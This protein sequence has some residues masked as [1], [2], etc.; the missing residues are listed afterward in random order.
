M[1][2]PIPVFDVDLARADGATD[3]QI[4]EFLASKAGFN[5]DLARKDGASDTAIVDFLTA[6]P[7]PA[8]PEKPAS[9]LMG[10]IAKTV[11]QNVLKLPGG[12]VEAA[13]ST[14]E[15]GALVDEANSRKQL[16]IYDRVDRG[17][18]IKPLAV[19]GMGYRQDQDLIWANQYA[20]ASPEEKDVLRSRAAGNLKA[21]P[22]MLE[23][24][25][26]KLRHSGEK[27]IGW[28]E[29]TI[30]LNEEE[31]G[32][33]SVQVT[34]LLTRMVPYVA[35][36]VATGGSG[37][38]GY[39][40][41][42]SLN[43]TYTE[44]LKEGA[45]PEKAAVGAVENGFMQGFLNVV[46]A[47]HAA[48]VMKR[49]PDAAKGKFVQLLADAALGA[50]NMLG[51]T[52]VSKLAENAVAEKTFD[53][54]RPW[55]KG[56]GEN[57]GP[58][59][60]A[61][62]ILPLGA[63]A[64]GA[65]ARRLRG[66]QPLEVA[67]E[68]TDQPTIDDAITKAREVVEGDPVDTEAQAIGAREFGGTAD[69]Q[70]AKML[71]LFGGLNEGAV[72]VL[73]GGQYQYRIDDKAIPLKIWDERTPAVEG[74]KTISP[75]LATTQRRVY[76][77]MG[78]DVV[79]IA[80]DGSVPFD[81][82]VSPRNPDTI[83]LSNDPQRNAAQVGA[84][85]IT[86][87][88][89]SVTTP[90]GERLAD[91]MHQKI[92]KD[93]TGAGIDHYLK[94]FGQDAPARADFEEGATGDSR[95][96]DAVWRHITQELGAD[97]GGEAPKFQTF[98]PKVI[99][100]VQARYGDDAAKSVTR[101]LMDGIQTAMRRL[102]E[103]FSKGDPGAE[104]GVPDTVSQTWLTNLGEMHDILAKGWAEK[105]GT[106]AERENVALRDMR[107]R[108]A[109]DRAIQDERFGVSEI[110]PPTAPEGFTS[111]DVT[112]QVRPD[113][114]GDPNAPLAAEVKRL[115]Q[116]RA[117]TNAKANEA[118][119]RGDTAERDRLFDEADKIRAQETEAQSR[120]DAAD[121]ERRTGATQPQG[122][123]APAPGYQEAAQKVS[124]YQRW[125][126][127][128]DEE[129][130]QAAPESPQAR[131][132][133]QTEAAILGKV[134]GVEDRL[135]KIAATRLG[136]VRTQ[137]DALLNPVDDSPSMAKVREGLLVEQQRMAD[138]AAARLPEKAPAA[139][140]SNPDPLARV[141]PVPVPSPEQTAKPGIVAQETAPAIPPSAPVTSATE[142]RAPI[143]AAPEPATPA[144]AAEIREVEQSIEEIRNEKNVRNRPDFAETQAQD[145]AELEA[146][147]AGLK[148]EGGDLRLEPT[149]GR[150]D[151]QLGQ[152]E[153]A[154]AKFSPKLDWV[155]RAFT[156]VLPKG[157]AWVEKAFNA[158]ADVRAAKTST[159]AEFAR[160][161]ESA[162]RRYDLPE[163]DYNRFV[164]RVGRLSLDDAGRLQQAIEQRTAQGDAYVP[165]E[166]LVGAR[167]RGPVT[168]VEP[169]EQAQIGQ[170]ADATAKFSPK[171]GEVVYR[172]T[173]E[174][175][176][177]LRA[178]DFSGAWV[179]PDRA[180]AS[181][182]G[183]H[184]AAHRISPEAKFVDEASPEGWAL[185]EKW[186]KSEGYSDADIR[187]IRDDGFIPDN[188]PIA[189]PDKK[190]AALL[191][192]AGYDGH[193]EGDNIFVAEHA[194]GKVAPDTEA[195]LSPKVS[196]ENDA[197]G[198]TTRA[199][200]LTGITRN[201]REAGYVTTDGTML[202]MSG[203]HEAVGYERR[204][205]RFTPQAGQP[206]YLANARNTDHRDVAQALTDGHTE[207]G[208]AMQEFMDRSGA[209]RVDFNSGNITATVRPTAEQ[210][211]A[212]AAAAKTAG[213]D[214]LTVEFM[215]ADGH[216]ISHAEVENINPKNI[217]RV[218]NDRLSGE[219]LFSP[220]QLETPE[221]KR[222]FGDSK[223][224]DEE[225][226]PIVVYHGTNAD[227]NV[228]NTNAGKGK[229]HGGG[230]IFT[231]RP[232]AANTYATG[233]NPNVMPAYVS[234]QNPVVIDAGGK[235]WN[236]IG[237]SARINLPET[238][239]SA[240]SDNKLLADLGV[241][242][243][244]NSPT[245]KLA[246][247][248]TTLGRI[249]KGEMGL[250][251][252]ASTDDV[253]RW[254]RSQGY[255]SVIIKNVVDRG[256]SGRFMTP[257]AS[258][259]QTLYVAFD[260][261]QIKSA[262][263]NTGA[264]DPTNPDIR[265]SPKGSASPERVREL[266]R[267]VGGLKGLLK[268]MEPDELAKL[269]KQ[270]ASKIV[271]VFTNLPSAEEMAAVAYAGRAKKGWY[272]KSAKALLEIFGVEDAPRF[273]ALL[274][275][276]SPQV[277]VETN[278]INALNIWKNWDAAGRPTDKHS[279]IGIM[280]ESVQ[281]DKGIDSVLGAWVNNTVSA[282]SHPDPEHLDISGPKVNSFARNLRGHVND[283][284]LDAW[285]ANYANIEQELFRKTGPAP[286]KGYGYIAMSA[287]V[288][289]AAD[290]ISRRT[291][292]TWTPA[293]IQETVWSWA[294][295]LYEAV[296][297]KEETRT[298]KQLLE[299][300]GL[301]HESIAATPDFELL[302]VSG[303]YR[304]LLQEAGY[305][306]EIQT[307]ERSVA[308]REQPGGA[309]RL[310]GTVLPSEGS[311][312]AETA[313]SGHLKRAANRLDQLRER[314]AA[315][316]EPRFSPK[317]EEP[318]YSALTRGVEGLKL[319]KATPGQWEATVRNM[320]GVKAEERAWVGLDD[321]LKLQPKSVTKA[322]V[323]DYLRAN[324]IKVQ[325]VEKG[326]ALITPSPETVERRAIQSAV[327][328]GDIE[329]SSF[330]PAARPE[331]RDF[332]L[333]AARDDIRAEKGDVSAT[334]FA[335]Y[336]L[337]GGSNYRELLLTLPEKKAG[338]VP[339]KVEDMTQPQLA[340]LFM[341]NDRHAEEHAVRNATREALLDLLVRGED[342]ITDDTLRDYQQRGMRMD[343]NINFRGGHWEEANVLAHIRFDDR[344]GPN[345]ERVLHI[346][347]VQS[348]WHQ[349]GRKEGYQIERKPLTKDSL[350][351]ALRDDGQ[352]V[353][354]DLLD[355]IYDEATKGREV[356]V[357]SL[358]QNLGL[359]LAAA[360]RIAGGFFDGGIPSGVPDA[361][362][363]TTWPELAMK[364]MLRFAAENG[365][366][367]VSWDT[368]ETNAD[369]FDLSQR[370]RELRIF[371]RADGDGYNVNGKTVEGD[372]ILHHAK[373]G[374][375]LV[376]TVG[377]ELA[378]R[379]V[380]ELDEQGS[381]TSQGVKYSGLDL[382][383]GGEGMAAFYD[384]QL[385]VIANKLG[386]KF[387]AKVEQTTVPTDKPGEV[388]QDASSRR[389]F[390]EDENGAMNTERTFA[391]EAEARKAIEAGAGA[392]SIAITDAMRDGVMQG[393]PL[394]SPKTPTANQKRTYTPEQDAA[395]KAIGAEIDVPTATEWARGKTRGAGE[396]TI[397]ATLDRYYG[398]KSDDPTGY[399]GLRNSNTSGGAI[400]G[401]NTIG[402]LKFVGSA[403]ALKD[404]TGGVKALI[405]GLGDEAHD[406]ARWV[407]GNRAAILKT[408]GRENLLDDRAI[409][410]LK[411]LNQ[412][413][414][415]EPYTLA[416]G[417]TTT[418]RE[419][420]YLDS[421]RKYHELNKNVMDL[422]VDSGLI[423]RD[424]ADK[425][426]ANPYYIPFYRVDPTDGDQFVAP[427]SRSAAVGQTAFQKLKG[428]TEKLNH[429][430]W[431]N[432]DSNFAHL[433]EASL[434]NKNA[435][436]VLK[437]AVQ[438]GAAVKLTEQQ[439]KYLSDKEQK[440]NTVWVMENGEKSYYRI[441]NE[442]LMAAVSVL[443]PIS[444]HGLVKVGQVAKTVLQTGVTMSP[445]FAVKNIIRDTQQ[446]LATT[447]ISWN[448][449]KNL[450]TGFKENNAGRA[451]M[452]LANAATAEV[453]QAVKPTQM[454][455]A[456]ANAMIGG[457]LMR[458][459]DVSDTGIRR[460]SI[461]SM[462]INTPEAATNFWEKLKV[463]GNA[464][465]K[466]LA[467]GEDVS[468]IAL[469][470]QLIDQGV[471]HDF[472]A[473][474]ARDIA[475]FTLTGASQLVRT[476]NSMSAFTNARMQGLYKVA[477]AAGDAD[478]SIVGAVATRLAV[479][480]MARV[481]I[482]VLAGTLAG[483]ALDRIYADDEDFKKRDE[484]DRNS[485]YWFKIG[486]TQ[487]RIPKGFEVGA[488]SSLGTIF[489]ESFYD[490]EMT[491]GRAGKNLLH[492]LADNLNLNPTPTAIKPILDVAMNKSAANGAPIVGKG[493]E[494]LDPT[495]RYTNSN[496]LAS[497]G[498]SKATFGALSPVQIDYLTRAYTG[499]L[500]TTS[501]QI[502]DIV[503]RSV[504]SEPVRP[505]GDMMSTLTGGIVSSEARASSRYINMLY[506][507]GDGIEKAYNT[508]RD[509][510]NSGRRAEAV[511]YYKAHQADID[512]HGIVSSTMRTEAALNAQIRRIGNSTEMTAAEK[513]AQIMRINQLKSD[514]AQRAVGVR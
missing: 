165:K 117:A 412:G 187:E 423:K 487:F 447:P 334:K 363:K 83:F 138:A 328:S 106:A 500:G 263:G 388:Y 198:L 197:A 195:K 70:Q 407:A 372:P 110:P 84:H 200:E 304:K 194:L 414:L 344:T 38:V 506:E 16:D 514:A 453:F 379:A 85:E 127:Q 8:K 504:S 209:V 233:D 43:Q 226:K 398:I 459:G 235:N 438:Q 89:E 50:G 75:E 205:D 309:D 9:S 454:S 61:G 128:L 52:E 143:S 245:S 280:G 230:T 81:G 499:W 346:A 252:T 401:F 213:L 30:P 316:E 99:D 133:Q 450:Y 489:V 35:A 350:A 92:V 373:D 6:T 307:V 410:G 136:R 20:G 129:R 318:F 478:K 39:G 36:A 343:S 102:R 448:V 168:D 22:G 69:R 237:A 279:I 342:P 460:T 123:P 192:E 444:R 78:I 483:L 433:I 243:S 147:L 191:K 432:V 2:D 101:K 142:N 313:F 203:R 364:R 285:M 164:E 403:Y 427:N 486:S 353:D 452:N 475:D 352:P 371:K 154:E 219:A 244:A 62:A 193:R 418:S 231:D 497:R 476:I 223:A 303:V 148:G 255:E 315:D 281:G 510:L 140:G 317:S 60:I 381:D 125:L 349:K 5:L 269:K 374:A 217:A 492:I 439:Y 267:E 227:I 485:N 32:R 135:T 435:I 3:T 90:D 294:K 1:A 229:T 479:N 369:R 29:R 283:V 429:D 216:P 264:F 472:A 431:E 178:R 171:Q 120:L 141:E 114:A 425:L 300:G 42:E 441:E 228:F 201:P 324:E 362:F 470:S 28:A 286:G 325:E 319:D 189:F 49:L 509:K 4:A 79:Y 10:G 389:W 100:E 366:D 65:A 404:R 495:E 451:L 361:P 468:R 375:A 254:A 15:V 33:T 382:K 386:K 51:M 177:E 77:D 68:I 261:T 118:N 174:R 215:G 482:V 416:N 474:S 163:A 234:L 246:A 302:F 484:M 330:W 24:T 116:E 370:V 507:Q 391:T 420:A 358:E 161:L 158:Y 426:L 169:V 97:I 145:I 471:P 494:R 480:T 419:A 166:P 462:L 501:M 367:R 320:P 224:V 82:A 204:G 502:G 488:M 186:L 44:A 463:A 155:R 179:T 188:D 287:A 25:G 11:G 23:E 262:I 55:N 91:L 80:D 183:E 268:Y 259:P 282:L 151:I 212:I 109:R 351:K 322:E 293:E 180:N 236:A 455:D 121:A 199:K 207:G 222:W 277:S 443:D 257:E 27:M 266:T 348:D 297:A 273:A 152:A 251:E 512:K 413:T 411:S 253:I 359:S 19:G 465:R 434:R 146:K 305:G 13:G 122:L 345:G 45:D 185:R 242:T 331:I 274:A 276:T 326:S 7:E 289:K 249:F 54:A 336:V 17:E 436:P 498:I 406:F 214:R 467:Q 34:D 105:F 94:I 409:K 72:E 378:D 238:E 40:A 111:A 182:Y 232:E 57:M 48:S 67:K 160:V 424:V 206:D 37:L 88:L 440:A 104:Y 247:Q 387:G 284:T 74:I 159:T 14:A 332:H 365:Y 18:K 150:S 53:P 513:K 167:R 466:A 355:A 241:D 490:K 76:R 356:L 66:K 323:L 21:E 415:A 385:P 377:K 446:V 402:T 64:A 376:N 225:G 115:Q 240:R 202:D 170:G 357:D 107:D 210:I 93:V 477:R 312:F 457:G 196:D 119:D 408:E 445:H 221:F 473:F 108:A 442:G 383:V 58:A 132:L 437:T 417:T 329:A 139:K 162:L 310:V 291:G 392:H 173:P 298:A 335:S 396:K 126:G 96:A 508:Y 56:L 144:R 339:L 340:D 311:G 260:P 296:S 112:G 275:A 503:A 87:I 41:L 397:I 103:F 278:A 308:G 156:A 306:R 461:T 71:Q 456:A 239:V 184:V 421:L 95:H 130:R 131:L 86:H 400:E 384:K 399:F 380:K 149:G 301:T 337:P 491:A 314:R 124:T 393:Q 290:V 321:W 272:Q 258:L 299:A 292:E 59:A 505:A 175:E 176:T 47:A 250:G 208:F 341:F 31:K 265:Y 137:L 220:K 394:F 395:L 172:G 248:S 428:G 157:D 347:E 218:F 181:Q 368:G 405:D 360:N 449:A 469:Y 211:S 98:L 430:L 271:E 327:A 46:P 153:G 493:M 481:G 464:W 190:W 390:I 26:K 73:P 256:P 270:N 63:G 511:E 354:G 12:V 288:R 333:N 338:P 422:A 113:P 134:N 295:T 458:F 496:T